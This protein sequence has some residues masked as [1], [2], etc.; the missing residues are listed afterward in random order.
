MI[1]QLTNNGGK[2]TLTLVGRLDTVAAQELN[3]ELQPLLAKQNSIESLVVDAEG[4]EYISSSGLRILLTLT[5]QYKDFRIISV[6]PAVYDVL[7]M[8]GFTKIMNVER[9]LR[10]LS[11]DGCEIIGIGGVGTV[12]RLDDDTIIKVFREGT[13][14]EEVRGEINMSKEAF[15]M[16][17]PT[18][19]SFDV[20][21][22]GG[23]YGLVYELLDADTLSAC[24]K[25]EPERIDEFAR[26]YA[27]LFRQ[28]HQIDVPA[29]SSVPCAMENERKQ[30]MHIRRYFPQESIDLL[31]QILDAIPN[32]RSLLHL[33]L[34]TK[35]AMVQNGEL[36]LIDMGEVGYGHP[37]LDLGHAYSAMVT[38]VGDYEKIIGM[39]KALGVE[40]WN[41]AIGYYLEGLPA[42]VVEQRKRQIE[43]VSCVRNFSWLALSD[44]FPEE[45]VNECKDVFEERVASR[46]DYIL[47]VCK[48]FGDWQI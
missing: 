5:K 39:P 17:M 14:I 25:R 40:L 35:N 29:S 9:A 12:Y 47:D 41:R 36:M 42:D 16:G 48:T 33:D 13:T 1:T 23:Q 46:R 37:L 18:A 4:L 6:Q 27:E 24:I 38:L 2:V 7:N 19:I 8:T 20:V 34:Q 45:V 31:M 11:V 28:L 26:R 3:A 44:S 22:V 30:V 15:V 43:V 10:N 21:K 32:G